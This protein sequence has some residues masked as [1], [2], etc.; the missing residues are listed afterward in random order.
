[1]LQ[2]DVIINITS[3]HMSMNFNTVYLRTVCV[4]VVQVL[5]RPVL[6]SI[7]YVYTQDLTH[8]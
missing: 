8:H 5:V 1:M 3:N 4:P 2:Y 7:Y 6:L